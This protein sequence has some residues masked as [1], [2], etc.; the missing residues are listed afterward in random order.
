MAAASSFPLSTKVTLGLTH[1]RISV[2][3]SGWGN[4]VASGIG[5]VGL[6]RVSDVEVVWNRK[7]ALV[8]IGLSDAPP[9]V[10]RAVDPTA[11][12]H[13]RDEFLRLRGRI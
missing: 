8:A 11:A 5:S 10:I 7:L 3:K 6:D 13:F 9:V 2:Y 1:R 12:E 4:K